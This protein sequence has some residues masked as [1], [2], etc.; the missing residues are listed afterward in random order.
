MDY[1]VFLKYFVGLMAIINPIGL[2]PVFSSLTSGNT[3]SE[4]LHINITANVA[5]A[6]ILFV[7]M[8]FGS[9]I[10]KWFSISLDSFRIAGGIM[11]VVI[12]L[13]MV[14]GQ[15]ERGRHNA[16]EKEEA[17][18]KNSIAVVSLAMPLMAGPDAISSTIVFSGQCSQSMIGLI[19][20]T[21][22]IIIFSVSSF[23]IFLSSQLMIKM[24]G[25]TG[26][27]IVTRIMG[28]IMMSIGIEMIAAGI[29]GLFYVK[30][31]LQYVTQG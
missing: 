15:L 18:L 28:I 29:K 11:I 3:K 13:V 7:S 9:L 31:F 23:L 24:M 1:T 19:G 8:L 27:N 12:A 21:L 2:L 16:D 17:Q 25:T 5:V 22:V 6:I 26:I 14:Q 10:L 20:S 30:E 4:R